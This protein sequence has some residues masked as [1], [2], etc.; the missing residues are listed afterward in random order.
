[1]NTSADEL[2]AHGPSFAKR[3]VMPG[4]LTRAELELFVRDAVMTYWHQTGT[5][6]MG[7]D[8]MSVV[9]G[10]LK[11]LGIVPEHTMAPLRH[12]RRT[13]RRNTLQAEHAL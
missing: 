11:V 13:R 5:V 2:V 8:A 12:H 4:N 9:D 3:E 10:T 7:Q 6:K 1:M